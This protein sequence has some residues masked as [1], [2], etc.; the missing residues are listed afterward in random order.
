MFGLSFWH[1]LLIVLVLL[2]LF[3]RG[4]LSSVMGDVG[5]GLSRYRREMSNSEKPP[6]RDP[7]ADG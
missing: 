6:E 2:L 5:R 3:G 7:R 4:R 1:I